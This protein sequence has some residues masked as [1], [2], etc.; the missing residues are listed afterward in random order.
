[1]KKILVLTMLASLVFSIQNAAT[2]FVNSSYAS[3]F[4][5]PTLVGLLYTVAACLALI[6]AHILPLVVSPQKAPRV[7]ITLISSLFVVLLFMSSVTSVTLFAILFVWYFAT[8]IFIYYCFDMIIE[9]ASPDAT[10]GRIRGVYLTG[11]SM[12]YLI[13]PF[14]SGLVIE[15]YGYTGLYVS[16]A[17]VLLFVISL[18]A[19][20]PKNPA[21]AAISQKR[22]PVAAY[23]LF[24]K[25]K[26]LRGVF[27]INFLLQFFYAW[28]VIYT[29]IYLHETLGIAWQT[30]GLMFTGMLSAFV[31]FQYFF[32]KL[33][34]KIGEQEIM[35]FGL[36]VVGIATPLIIISNSA[37]P[38]LLAV[39]L[40]ITRIGASALEVSS[41][42]FFFKHINA[43]QNRSLSIFRSTFPLAYIIAPALASLV[44]DTQPIE[45]LFFILGGILVIGAL[46]P[47]TIQDT[48]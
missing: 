21:T 17:S 44:L 26:N 6:G 38:L 31:L 28:M 3:T 18:I 27:I 24:F 23:R 22:E 33:A 42:S 45:T 35:T 10:T 37:V 41:E 43:G 14:L 30:I 47:I 32:G 4:I 39:I 2:L 7:L 11:L 29:P 12:G 13:G 8:T 46:M 48:K 40:F 20:V 16:A 36:L 15:H 9:S 19:F 1:M 25:N 34:D 5:E